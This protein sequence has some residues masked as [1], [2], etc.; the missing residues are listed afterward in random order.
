MRRHLHKRCP[1][2][3]HTATTIVA[4]AYTATHTATTIAASAQTT[5]P[6]SAHIL[7]PSQP[8]PTVPTATD[9]NMANFPTPFL[10][11]SEFV[12]T[13]LQCSRDSDSPM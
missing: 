9:T 1:T 8:H 11:L 13:D 12:L 7:S 6:T 5:M 10:R 3:V 2:A 4:S